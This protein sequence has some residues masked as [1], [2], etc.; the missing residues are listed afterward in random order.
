MHAA[1]RHGTPSLT[2][3]P[4]DDEVS[5][6]EAT[7]TV[8]GMQQQQLSKK[9]LLICSKLHNSNLISE[10]GITLRGHTFRPLLRVIS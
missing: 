9:R 6:P 1:S 10:Y 2:S 8:F 5:R 4:K 7:S 3:L